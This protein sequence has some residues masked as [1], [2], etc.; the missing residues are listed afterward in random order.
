VGFWVLFLDSSSWYASSLKNG[1]LSCERRPMQVGQLKMVPKKSDSAIQNKQILKNFMH[2]PLFY[3]NRNYTPLGSKRTIK[4]YIRGKKA[5]SLR[6]FG[7]LNRKN[8][9]NKHN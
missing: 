6:E 7:N 1:G 2:P 5:G 8:T 3:S 9:L 4:P